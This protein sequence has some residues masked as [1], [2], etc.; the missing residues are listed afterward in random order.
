M[1]CYTECM[2]AFIVRLAEDSPYGNKKGS[3]LVNAPDV[4]VAKERRACL[5]RVNVNQVTAVSYGGVTLGTEFPS[6]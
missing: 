3:V 2:A 1:L 4:N 6:T 5:L